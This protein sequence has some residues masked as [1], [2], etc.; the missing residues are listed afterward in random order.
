LELPFSQ[1]T[2]Y[3]EKWGGYAMMIVGYDDDGYGKSNGA[4]AFKVRNSWGDDWGDGGYRYLPCVLVD[5][6]SGSGASSDWP[7]YQDENFVY[8]ASISHN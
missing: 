6:E 1:T 2:D 4:G 5:G 3:E 8:V 7:V